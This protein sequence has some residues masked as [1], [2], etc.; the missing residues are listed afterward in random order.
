MD[1]KIKKALD[2]DSPLHDKLLQH[3]KLLVE[4]SRNYMSG[5]YPRWEAADWLMRTQRIADEQ[6]SKAVKRGEPAKTVLPFSYAQAQTFVA[7]FIM[8]FSQR[9]KFYEIEDDE[10]SDRQTEDDTERL[11]DKDLQR[12]KFTRVMYQCFLDLCRCGLCAVKSMWEEQQTTENVP[13]PPNP[14]AGPDLFGNVLPS[15]QTTSKTS[16]KKQGNKVMNVSPFR[17]FP[18]TRFALSR[19][20]E[21]EF[22]ASEDEYS[23]PRLKQMEK[24]GT[25]V[26]SDKIKELKPES[27]E[28][29]RLLGYNADSAN[30]LTSGTI[31]GKGRGTAVVTEIQVWITPKDFE[32]DD[33]EHPLG[34]EDSPV[35]Y[36]IWYANDETI[37]KAEPLNYPYNEFTYDVGELSS[38][39][40]KVVNESLTEI[41][42]SMQEIATWFINSRLTSVRKVIDNKIIVDPTGIEVQDLIDRKPV[43]RLKAGMGRTGVENYIKQL[44][45]QDVT[46]GHVQDAMTFWQ[47]IQ[48]CTGINDNALGQYHGGRRSAAEART[49]NAGA[50]SRLKTIA[51][52]LWECMFIPLGEKLMCNHQRLLSRDEFAR[53]V[54]IPKDSPTIDARY[55]AFVAAEPNF[56]FFDGTAPSEK[57]YIAQSMQELLLGLLANPQTAL[58]LGQEP[59]RSFIVEIADLRGIRSPER[60]LPPLQPP[61]PPT[62]PIVL[63]NANANPN[64]P[65]TAGGAPTGLPPAAGAAA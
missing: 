38:D 57:G 54:G 64:Q 45:V 1:D 63:P 60:F 51:Q 53:I 31:S 40:L 47:F 9:S 6:D 46:T 41:I 13:V 56:E 23:L 3:V 16:Y 37:L 8:L 48:I 55:E 43:I 62:P 18:D 35:L 11:L 21:G 30:P 20:Q 17:F 5:F 36:V 34:T 7:F 61:A 14:N 19:F 2:V 32:G 22:C 59:F 65:P 24:N 26:N 58:L 29:R 39:Q 25:I 12:S 27:L 49:V 33:N 15:A 50:A 28:Q 44:D 52:V 42:A 10:S 4:M